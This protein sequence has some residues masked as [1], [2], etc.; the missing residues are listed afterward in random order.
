MYSS[1]LGIN[2]AHL[3]NIMTINDGSWNRSDYT[4]GSIGLSNKAKLMRILCEWPLD[5]L[6]A[7]AWPENWTKRLWVTIIEKVIV[8]DENTQ[9]FYCIHT[10]LFIHLSTVAYSTEAKWEN[11]AAASLNECNLQ[12]ITDHKS[13]SLVC[14][15]TMKV[16]D[17]WLSYLLL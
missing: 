14:H 16:S 7:W 12:Y 15:S 9:T 3:W 8:H 1:Q 13:Q 17:R 11:V 6:F 4:I 5:V 10:S 2:V